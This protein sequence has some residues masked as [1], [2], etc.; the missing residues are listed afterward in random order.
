M[1]EQEFY[2][3]VLDIIKPWK[4]ERVELDRSNSEAHVYLKSLVSKIN[5]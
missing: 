1:N 4:V 3:T 2:E 5:R